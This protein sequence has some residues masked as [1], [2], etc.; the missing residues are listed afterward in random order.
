MAEP[1]LALVAV[2]RFAALPSLFFTCVCVESPPY[3][4]VSCP[5]NMKQ[6]SSSSRFF[7][8]PLVSGGQ[9][10]N[11]VSPFFQLPF[12]TSV[13]IQN[14]CDSCLLGG[15]QITNITCLIIWALPGQPDYFIV[16]KLWRGFR[17]FCV[18]YT[19]L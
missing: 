18:L 4:R 10:Y 15:A 3:H 5:N 6:E 13:G 19:L 1:G 17:H 16:D 12:R 14:Y 8:I 9:A 2:D 7:A 11:H